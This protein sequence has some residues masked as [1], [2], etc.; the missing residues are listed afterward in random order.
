MRT[1]ARGTAVLKPSPVRSAESHEHVSVS[2]SCLF[3]L[4]LCLSVVPHSHFPFHFPFLI[5]PAVCL[6]PACLSPCLGVSLFFCHYRPSLCL[7]VLCLLSVL[8]LLMSYNLYLTVIISVPLC[9]IVLSFYHLTSLWLVV[10]LHLPQPLSLCP[11][12]VNFSLSVPLFVCFSVS[13]FICLSLAHYYQA[14]HVY[15]VN[16][17]NLVF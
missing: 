14:S 1:K 7:S 16:W 4:S 15:S 5:C 11:C 17:Y 3:F 13:R 2:R 12:P 9:I 8:S 10:L 6:S